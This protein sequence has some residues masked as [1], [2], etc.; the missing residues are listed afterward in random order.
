MYYD[1]DNNPIFSEKFGFI[2]VLRNEYQTLYDYLTD[3]Y[4]GSFKQQQI[5]YYIDGSLS[6]FNTNIHFNNTV[7][8]EL[9]PELLAIDS[10]KLNDNLISKSEVSI[11]EKNAESPETGSSQ[12]AGNKSDKSFEATQINN[13]AYLQ[14]ESAVN[15]E[16]VILNTVFVYNDGGN[17]YRQAHSLQNVSWHND[18]DLIDV[19][20]DFYTDIDYNNGTAINHLDT[21]NILDFANNYN[22]QFNQAELIAKLITYVWNQDKQHTLEI[23]MNYEDCVIAGYI[24]YDL[25]VGSI[26]PI[27]IDLSN[28]LKHNIIFDNDLYSILKSEYD[29]V[30]NE[31]KMTVISLKDISI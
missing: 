15:D 29:M 5:G 31:V 21:A 13:N 23:T 20:T 9:N 3:F 17:F 2:N 30:T 7:Y 26:M 22:S 25:I 6:T 1:M 24:N 12:I 11:L 19:P 28:T 27:K 8:T 16:K 4:K 18:F 10:I 14:T